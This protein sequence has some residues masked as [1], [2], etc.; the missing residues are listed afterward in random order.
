[1]TETVQPLASILKEYGGW[2]LSVILMLVCR[3]LY[4]EVVSANAR[5]INMAERILPL[6]TT[7]LPL[8]AEFQRLARQHEHERDEK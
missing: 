1:M 7:M 3:F 8:I 6:V 2:A 5:N 4:H